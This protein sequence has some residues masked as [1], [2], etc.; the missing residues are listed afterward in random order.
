MKENHENFASSGEKCDH[1]SQLDI[2]PFNIDPKNNTF[3]SGNSRFKALF[4]RVYVKY[5]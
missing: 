4:G 1:L 5:C 3:F 2:L